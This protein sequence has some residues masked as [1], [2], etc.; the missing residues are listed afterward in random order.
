MLKLGVMTRTRGATSGHKNMVR[1]ILSDDIAIVR[2]GLR[3]ILKDRQDFE[4]CAET[5]NSRDAVKLAQQHKPDVIILNISFPMINEL[6]A[7]RQIRAQSL[8]TEVMAFTALDRDKQ[9]QEIISAGARGYVMKSETGSEIIRAVEALS[10]HRVFFSKTISELLLE[11]ISKKIAAAPPE[12]LTCREREVVKMI[13]AGNSNKK[14]A[15]FLNISVKTVESHRSASMR[16]LKVHSTA[17]LV[18]YAFRERLVQ[19]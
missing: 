14:T 1:I 2:R 10:Q 7:I 18:R 11:I 12:E 6:D 5:D 17:Q 4:V 15:H 16:K 13:A 9:V 3:A 19:N 8:G